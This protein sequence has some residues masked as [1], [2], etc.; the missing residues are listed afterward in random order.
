MEGSTGFVIITVVGLMSLILPLA[1][2]VILVN[3]LRKVENLEKVIDG[4]SK[5]KTPLA[6]PTPT[7]A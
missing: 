3:L 2:V 4:L 7:D 5:N 1:S 6:A